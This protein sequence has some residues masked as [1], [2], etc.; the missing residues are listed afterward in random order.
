MEPICKAG[1]AKPFKP[2]FGNNKKGDNTN[3]PRTEARVLT[4]SFCWVPVG[5]KPQALVFESCRLW[6]SRVA[7]SGK[8]P[9]SPDSR[10]CKARVLR[11][12][13]PTKTTNTTNTTIEYY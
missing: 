12:Q 4:T 11:M 7:G 10:N 9:E 8:K 1:K 5:K 6:Y 13:A 3:L 2:R